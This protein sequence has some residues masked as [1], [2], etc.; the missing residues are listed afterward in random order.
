MGEKWFKAINTLGFLFQI[1]H[2]NEEVI[3]TN[4]I[5][6]ILLQKVQRYMRSHFYKSFIYITITVF[7]QNHKMSPLVLPS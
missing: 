7:P 4:S 1:L 6:F 5:K 2:F 3:K